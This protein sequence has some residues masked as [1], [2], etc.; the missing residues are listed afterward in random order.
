[1]F[2]I[3]LHKIQGWTS[4]DYP[5]KMFLLLFTK[6]INLPFSTPVAFIYFSLS[7]GSKGNLWKEIFVLEFQLLQPKKN[8]I[9]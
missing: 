6:H 3:R 9:K 7:M 1:M 2:F 8:V 4:L 5:D